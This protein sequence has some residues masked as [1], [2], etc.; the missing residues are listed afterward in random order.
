MTKVYVKYKD[1]IIDPEAENT[2]KALKML[3]YDVK[4]VRI[5]KVYEIETEDNIKEMVERLL[6]NPVIHEYKIE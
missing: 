4:N 1:G 6:V 5:W 3:G 2:K